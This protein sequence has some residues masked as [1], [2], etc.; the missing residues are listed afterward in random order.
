MWGGR[1]VETLAVRNDDWL[2][3]MISMACGYL[4][5]SLALKLQETLVCDHGEGVIEDWQD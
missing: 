1:N 5:T 4:S 3:K 2:A